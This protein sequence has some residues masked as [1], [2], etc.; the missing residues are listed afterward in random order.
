MG[1]YSN[2]CAGVVTYNPEISQLKANLDSLT[3]QV[4]V[5]YVVDNGS[6]N[7]EKIKSILR[8]YDNVKLFCNMKNLGISK[9]LN[10]LCEMAM[11]DGYM[12]ILTM[13]QDS[14]CMPKMVDALSRFVDNS[15]GIIA[16]RVEFWTKGI[17]ILATKD[18]DKLTTEVPACITSGSL[19]NLIAWNH[20]GGFDE[21]LF[22]DHVDNDFCIRLKIAGYKIIRVHKGVLYQ[23]AGEMDY[24]SLPF[25]RKI[26]LPHYSAIRQYY[27]CRN[28]IYYLR[29][30]KDRI[31]FIHE[32]GVFIYSIIIK[33]LFE[34]ERYLTLSST[35]K[36]VFAGFQKEISH[37]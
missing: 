18:G 31:H 36:G 28:T 11:R 21:W 3:P 17:M 26:L 8:K 6:S 24:F 13:D 2:I 14:L 29:K 10:Q 9:A 25:G 19:T 32:L 37:H 7:I 30:Y 33:L 1:Y 12:W 4:S 5:V 34:E 16:P 27:S 20:V 15:I 22:I 23:R 35:L